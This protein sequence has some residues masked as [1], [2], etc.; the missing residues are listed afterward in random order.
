[1]SHQRAMN[2]A[3]LELVKANM[4]WQDGEIA[5]RRSP[6]RPR[7]DAGSW[8]LAIWNGPQTWGLKTAQEL[9]PSVNLTLTKRFN[10]PHDRDDD[11]LI[12][13]EDGITEKMA[14]L[15]STLYALQNDIRYRAD[16]LMP[17]GYSGFVTAPKPMSVTAA[18]ECT[19]QWFGGTQAH[20]THGKTRG[21]FTGGDSGV[22][23]LRMTVNFG[24]WSF[25]HPWD[26][27]RV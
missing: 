15:T 14:V 7:P 3:T 5:V 11:V 18:E 22:Y 20:E 27:G 6:G 8:F 17:E 16:E 9:F 1:M 12:A 13:E 4:G 19:A 10:N 2:Q 25:I 26:L 24:N 23:G 21:Q